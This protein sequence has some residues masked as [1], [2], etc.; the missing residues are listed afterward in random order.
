VDLDMRKSKSNLHL[1]VQDPTKGVSTVLI[2][3]NTWQE[4]VS[5]TPIENFDYLPAGPH[6]PNPA[7]LLLNGEFKE[8]LNNLREH[9]DY[10]L[11]DTPPVGLVTDGIM[12]MK[13]ADLCIY[14][15]RANYS[16]SDFLLNLQ[17][18]IN[19]NKFSNLTMVLNALPSTGE[20]KYG[21][22]YYTEAEGRTNWKQLF[23]S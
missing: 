11:V 19:I 2:R 7:E 13:H 18:I 10:V 5:Q 15:F 6:P 17:R 21:Y 23:N 12:A 4:C 22:G 1:P 16:K 20:H 8:L 9:Y 14:I 3:R